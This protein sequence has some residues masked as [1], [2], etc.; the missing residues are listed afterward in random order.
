[1]QL[2]WKIQFNWRLKGLFKKAGNFEIFYVYALFEKTN[3]YPDF[4]TA[5]RLYFLHNSQGEKL[6][7][8]LWSTEKSKGF[9]A[10]NT[11]SKRRKSQK[12]WALRNTNFSYIFL[13]SKCPNFCNT[14]LHYTIF[15]DSCESSVPPFLFSFTEVAIN[16]AEWKVKF[17][18]N[19][20]SCKIW[21][22]FSMS[23]IAYL[24]FQWSPMMKTLN[25]W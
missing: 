16:F 25:L 14:F 5:R 9:S 10:T 6:N 11:S 15:K 4:F 24:V 3:D 8:V 20:K 1:M 17:I 23:V 13:K 21:S 2:F 18:K 12:I 22:I 7:C 19:V